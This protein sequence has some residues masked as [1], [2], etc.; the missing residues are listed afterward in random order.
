MIAIVIPGEPKG[1]GRPRLG[2]SFTYTPKDTVNYENLVKVCYMDQAKN[3]KLDGELKATI[4]AYYSIP[5]STS[6]KKRLEMVEERLRP[7][8]KPDLDNVAKI[9]LDSLN[10]VAFDDDSQIVKLEVEKFYS[11][12]PRVELQL[13]SV[14]HEYM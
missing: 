1:K 2:K 8:K 13:E 5:K 10:K 14:S 12:N 11:E 7:I 3:L 9:V 6:K 4:I